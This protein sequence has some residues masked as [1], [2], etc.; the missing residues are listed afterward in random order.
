MA[1]RA[2][3]SADEGDRIV[4]NKLGI[5][6]DYQDWLLPQLDQHQLLEQGRGFQ[7]GVLEKNV[8][9]LCGSALEVD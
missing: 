6:V 3:T 1:L 7:F 5:G 8:Q 9:S 2:R 4:G